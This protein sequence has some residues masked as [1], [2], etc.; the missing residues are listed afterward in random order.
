MEEI[1]MVYKHW[2]VIGKGS[3]YGYVRCQCIECGYERDISKYH[4]VRG[5]GPKCECMKVP[6][7]GR[8]YGYWEVIGECSDSSKVLCKCHK[9]GKTVREVRKAG[10]TSGRSQSCGCDLSDRV[11]TRVQLKRNLFGKTFGEWKVIDYAGNSLWECKCSCGTVRN[12][13][14]FD[15][16]NGKTTSCGCMKAKRYKTSMLERYGVENISQLDCKIDAEQ[17]SILQ[18]ESQLRMFI[19]S[20]DPP[21]TIEKLSRTLGVNSGSMWVYVRKHKLEGL[22][23]VCVAGSQ[24]EDEIALFLD[25]LGVKYIRHDRDAL[26]KQEID[27]YIPSLRFGIEFN[28]SYWHSELFKVMR[29]HQRKNSLA[30][31]NDIRLLQ[32]FEYEWKDEELKNKLKSL[33]KRIVRP[34][35]NRVLHARNCELC[36]VDK[37]E[38]KQFQNEYHLM[39]SSSAEIHIGL[40][41]SGELIGI[42]TF[43]KPRFNKS[44][45]YEMVRMVWKDGVAVSGGAEKLFKGFITKYKTSSIITYAELSKFTGSVYTRLG[46][47][48]DG[49]TD[50]EYVWYN[51]TNRDVL[52]RYKTQKDRLVANGLGDE[53]ESEADI[54]LKHG[55]ARIYNCGNARFIWRA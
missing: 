33:I 55:Y 40:R 46:F 53:S 19:E 1:G 17:R 42:M 39:G 6:W 24:Y 8:K 44:V 4:L 43:G 20:I 48:Y 52:N 23:D 32:I 47:T 15:L 30:V 36:E 12:I 37:E 7:V 27:L 14:G 21:R 25:S 10:L 22:T 50:P 18:D 51:P 34:D 38:S 45:E 29:Y 2:E 49:M 35:L 3:R 9:C 16:E 41:H 5:N 26:K 13:S 28:G 54:M 11:V 31:D